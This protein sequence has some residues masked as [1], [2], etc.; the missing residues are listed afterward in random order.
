MKP[1]RIYSLDLLRG[2]VMILMALDH[3]RH[4]LHNSSCDPENLECTSPILFFTRWITH[5][6]APVFI[7]LV[8]I[9]TYLYTEKN[10]KVKATKFLLT[11]GLFLI[12]L[13]L[14]VLR[15]AWFKD[16]TRPV[17]V[18][19]VIWAIGMSMIFLGMV[20]RY[21]N[22][23][24][25][26]IIGALL[27]FGHNLLDRFQPDPSSLY[28]KLGILLHYQ[29]Q[30]KLTDSFSVYVLY[31][32]L[33]YFGLISLGYCAG[34]LFSK[35]YNPEKRRNYLLI[36]GI[37]CIGLFILLRLLNQYGDPKPWVPQKNIVYTILAFLRTTKY[38]TSLLYLLMTIGPA[39]LVLYCFD[40]KVPGTL[41]PI[42]EIGQVPMFFYIV[43]LFLIKYTAILYGGLAALS[44]KEVYGAW[45][46]Y[47]LVLY[48]LCRYYGKYK[49]AH[50]EKKWLSYL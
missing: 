8:G 34:Q 3:S 21:L 47:I 39:L 32:L 27:V 25:L 10:N 20:S 38:P 49:F 19:M 23:K 11:R 48:G 24:T 45:I 9:S 4:F 12:F 29:E 28:G 37:A 26:L 50:P 6:C 44:L 15:F 36:G 16:F 2:I 1:N 43:H 17:I 33:P 30:F 35:T 13:E 18:L 7:F 31:P 42:I 46:I 22:S 14:V 40:K 41:R 5:Y